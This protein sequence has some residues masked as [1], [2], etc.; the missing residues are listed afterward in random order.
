MAVTSTST[1]TNTIDSINNVAK[2]LKYSIPYFA[3]TNFGV[4]D[5]IAERKGNTMKWYRPVAAG[6]TTA[7][8][9]E[10]PT[11]APA[12][13]SVDSVTSQLELRGDGKEITE[14]LDIYS[15]FDL[16]QDLQRWAGENAAKS[17][18]GVTRNV[19]TAGVPTGQYVYVNNKSASTLGTADTADLATFAEAARKLRDNDAPAFHMGGQ[20]VYVAI[21]SPSVKTQ[22]MTTSSFREAVRYAD[23]NRLFYGHIGTMDGLLFVETSTA[24]GATANTTGAITADQSLVIGDGYYGVPS[25]PLIGQAGT[26]PMQSGIAVDS[27]TAMEYESALRQMFQ[28]VITQPGDGNGGGAHGDEWATKYK[29]AW[30]A[31]YKAVIL[32]TNYAQLVRSARV[33]A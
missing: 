32:N 2:A 11:W 7:T 19:L 23:A 31:L 27:Q 18:N 22:L 25:M 10:S 24:N 16:R 28:I 4:K 17:L 3:Y 13:H 1:L 29:V 30:K 20:P 9:A 33:R 14:L 21:I 12:T 26:Y 5:S 15:V 6:E 8:L